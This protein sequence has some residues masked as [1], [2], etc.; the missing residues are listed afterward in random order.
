MTNT[1]IPDPHD[2]ALVLSV[3]STIRPLIESIN[4]YHPLYVIFIAS[5]ETNAN[6]TEILQQTGGI[7]KHGTITLSDYQNLLECVRDIREELPKKLDAMSLPADTLL[8]ADITGGTKVMSAALALAMMEFNSRFTYVG[9]DKRGGP[10]DRVED[11][12]EKIM[13]MDNPWDV[14]GVRE[15][16]SLAQ[17]FNAG[18][19]EAAREKADFLRSK[20]S[21]YNAFYGGIGAAIE[22]FRHWDSFSHDN[23]CK[24]LKHALGRLA[25]YD[26]RRH[27]NFR[28]LYAQLQAAYETLAKISQD[29]AALLEPFRQ[30]E[31]G[32]GDA[33]LRDL[34]GNARRRAQ[35]G[36]YDDAV[37]RLYSAIEKTAKIALAQKGVN[38]SAVTRET[39]EKAGG[40]L[41][42]KYAGEPDGEIRLPLGASFLLLGSLEPGHSAACAYGRHMDALAKN[43]ETR[44]KSLLAHGYRPVKAEDYQKLFGI[45]LQF[46][47]I[48][49]EDLPDFPALEVNSILF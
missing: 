19:F 37:A 2:F 44:N 10:G 9:G 22:A 48:G 43:L 25:P 49:E 41:A 1:N 34:V 6:V 18:Q 17:A 36:H 23:A 7:L 42:E 47:G 38:N 45:A 3:G 33:Y 12:H 20:N 28:P 8:I 21:E 29:A 15:A 24:E 16:A 32:L 35:R 31:P 30:L 46:L 11:G 26:N 40:E 4:Y 13:P 39:L 27:E 14:I 5:R